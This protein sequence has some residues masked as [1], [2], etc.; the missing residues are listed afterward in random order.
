MKTWVVLI[1]ALFMTACQGDDGGGGGGTAVTTT[2]VTTPLTSCLD[3]TT[4]CN[5]QQYSGLPGFMPYP[6]MYGYAYNYMTY[7]NQN[8]FCNCPQGW[9]P[10]YNS[11][12]GLGCV[13]SRLLMQNYSAS[14]LYWEFQ[15]SSS[16]SYG[17]AQSNDYYYWSY[18]SAPT[19][20]N[21]FAQSSNIPNGYYGGSGGSCSRNLT[22]SCLL[23][24]ANTC[25][26]GATC[27]QVIAGSSLGVCANY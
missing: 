21:N 6:G 16:W 10:V 5:N 25:G 14:Y 17:W 2:T 24:Q 22:Q 4:Y 26:A 18:Y 23:N 20:P 15:N 9:T 27:R 11:S 13:Q 3:G 8:G 19:I 1:F 12:Y 7:F